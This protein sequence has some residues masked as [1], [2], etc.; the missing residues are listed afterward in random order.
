[1][2][3]IGLIYGSDT[4]ITEEITNSI[5]DKWTLSPINV[6]EASHVKNSDIENYDILIL[7][8]STWYDGDLQ[9]DWENYFKKFKTMDFTN[10]TI[11]LYGLGD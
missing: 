1:M 8:L 3:T 11:A 9:S 4:G 2:K 5:V 7:G 6:Y 10:K